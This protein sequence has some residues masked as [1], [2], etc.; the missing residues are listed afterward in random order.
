MTVLVDT[1]V[2]VEF[3]DRFN[4]VVRDDMKELLRK[5]EVAT[6]GLVAAEL[7]RGA[8][9]PAQVAAI[10]DAMA[11]LIYLEADQATWLRAGELAAEGVARGRR[12]EIGDC[13]LAALA[14][15]EGC[16]L[17]TLDRDFEHIPGVKLYRVRP[18]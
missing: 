6:S 15:R 7:R 14:M 8:R 12:L 16:L 4:P 11:P 13:L 3:L 10:L 9:S 1:S 17:F 18:N 5:G 2:W